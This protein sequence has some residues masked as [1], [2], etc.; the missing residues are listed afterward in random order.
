[1]R[2]DTAGLAPFG[3]RLHEELKTRLDEA[4]KDG[5]RSLNSEMVLRLED[6][7]K[8]PLQAHSD[9]DLIA[10]LMERYERGDI[11]IRIGPLDTEEK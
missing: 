9:A 10:E 5:G 1:M 6:S 2:R 7:F 11:Y 3:L 8:R 4:A